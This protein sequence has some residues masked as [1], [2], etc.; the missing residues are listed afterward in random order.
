MKYVYIDSNIWLSLYHFSSDDLEQ[1]HKLK[2]LV[3]A[4]IYLLIPQQTRD[5][6]I[7]NRDAKVKD[8]LSKFERFSFEFPAFSKN[9]E[10]Y[11]DFS[12]RYNL[13]K[14]EHKLWLK[15]VKKDVQSQS[16]SADL[17]LNDF[18]AC[19][20]LL[21][22]DDSIIRRAELRYKSGN[23]PGKDNRLGDAINW[24]CLLENVPEG[25]DLYFISGDKDYASVID[26]NSFNHFLMDEWKR[27]KKSTVLF[28]KSL[29]SFLNQYIGDIKLQ[30]EQEKDDLIDALKCSR[31][32]AN[33]H[34]VIEKLAKYTEWTDVQREGLFEAAINNTQVSWI[35]GDDDV[36][37]F[38]TRLR[39]NEPQ[40]I[41]EASSAV[42]KMLEDSGREEN[43]EDDEL[44]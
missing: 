12:K 36:Y 37:S 33:T 35:I 44:Q 2:Q 32:F 9:Y 23:P 41:S 13:L 29:V 22:C 1:F 11:A 26:D 34:I 16:L 30:H 6:V 20:L 27:T 14:D 18:F 39:E 3:G 8:A 43:V 19:D 21:P 31:N 24:E 5:E 42:K 10:E 28:F 17:V 38:Y 40:P 15:K 4:G 25:E 7:R